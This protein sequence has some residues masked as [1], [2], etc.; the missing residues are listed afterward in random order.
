L[1]SLVDRLG[2][3]VERTVTLLGQRRV[4]ELKAHVSGSVNQNL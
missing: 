4:Q 3:V 2:R 1:T